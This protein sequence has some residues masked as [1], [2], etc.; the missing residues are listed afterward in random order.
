M[1]LDLVIMAK[2]QY[3]I[4]INPTEVIGARRA[5]RDDPEVMERLRT[6]W[7]AG[8]KASTFD[9]FVDELIAREFPPVVIHFGDGFEAAI[10]AVAA[11]GQYYGYRGKAIEPAGNRISAFAESNGHDLS[12]L[13]GKHGTKRVIESRINLLQR[14]LDGYRD[15]N[16]EITTITEEYYHVWRRRDFAELEKLEQSF[17]DDPDSKDHIFELYSYF[18]AIDWFRFWADKGFAIAA[19]Y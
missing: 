10:P 6:V 14:I 19:E 2:Q 11:E 16:A 3:G 15:D 9:E 7:D 17:P 5:S 1:G 4:E 8:D 18:G 12:W 13:Y